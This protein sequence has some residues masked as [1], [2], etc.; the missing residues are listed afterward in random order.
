MQQDGNHTFS[1]QGSGT[2]NQQKGKDG[3]LED[4]MK[5]QNGF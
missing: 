2:M 5:G 3:S 4:M 1:R